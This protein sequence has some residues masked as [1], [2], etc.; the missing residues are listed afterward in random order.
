MPVR[1]GGAVPRGLPTLLGGTLLGATLVYGLVNR[2][3]GHRYETVIGLLALLGAAGALYLLWNADPVS[4]LSLGLVLSVFEW[5]ELAPWMPLGPDRIVLVTAIAALLL[6]APRARN[7]PALRLGPEAALLGIA[8]A[9][10]VVSAALAGSLTTSG[11]FFTLFDRY[12][13]LPFVLFLVAPLAFRD[14]ERRAVL[15]VALVALGGYL[16][17]TALFEAAGA[18]ALVFPRYILDEAAGI[19]FGRARGPFVQAAANGFALFACGVAAA[20]ALSVWRQLPA[21]LAAGAVL[22]LCAAGC[23]FTLQRTVWLAAAAAALVAL[24]A[25]QELRRYLVPA[26]VVVVLV[27]AGAFAAIPGLSVRAEE[28]RDNERSIWD[29]RNTNAAALRLIADKPLTGTGWHRFAQERFPYYRQ[30]EGYP[31]T[32]DGEIVHN[33]FLSNAAELG[34]P[35]AMLWLAAAAAAIGG[36]LLARGPPELRPWRIGLLALAVFWLVAANVSPLLQ[37]FPN[38][39]LWMW[40]GVVMAGRPQHHRSFTPRAAESANLAPWGRRAPAAS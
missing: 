9:C 2:L 35:I 39:V 1:R 12:G 3:P 26:A 23:L 34:L 5:G 30:A 7:R 38:L 19:H 36:A 31:L 6:R 17:L 32:F 22:L 14:H 28:R 40:A 10:A 21:R 15:L 8:L 11:G 18:R 13:A 4:M 24:L 20:I 37:P 16:G 29:R 25:A 27:V 33:V